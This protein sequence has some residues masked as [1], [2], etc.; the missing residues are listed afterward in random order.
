MGIASYQIAGFEADDI[1]ATLAHLCAQDG[2]HVTLVTRDKDFNQLL[3]DSRVR[4]YDKMTEKFSTPETCRKKYGVGPAEF[5]EAQ[6]LMGDPGDNVP[7]VPGCGPKTAFRLIQEYGTV[8]LLWANRATIAQ[9]ALRRK[10]ETSWDIII[11]NRAL[12][13]LRKD[14]PLPAGV[15]DTR[16][17]SV[18]EAVR[19]ARGLFRTLGFQFDRWFSKGV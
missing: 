9:P 3:T 4:L 2:L 18:E 6:V 16:C 7:S 8:S 1:A 15:G 5:L 17:P 12:V 13:T 10:I 11:R 19:S 14:V